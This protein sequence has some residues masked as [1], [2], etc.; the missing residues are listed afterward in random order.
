MGKK[1]GWH[2]W[3]GVLAS[4]AALSVTV[5]NAQAEK[6]D[7][8]HLQLI[9]G[10]K[11]VEDLV[12]INPDWVIGSGFDISNAPGHLYLVDTHSNK[13]EDLLPNISVKVDARAYPACPG[14]PDFD[15]LTPHGLDYY[16]QQH[17]LFVVNHGGR[18]SIEV[19]QLSPEAVGE[20]PKLTWVG[21]TLA[22]PHTYLDAVVGVKNNEM[23]VS[24]LWNPDDPAKNR[25]LAAGQPEGALYHW[26]EGGGFRAIEAAKAFSGPNGVLATRDGQTLFVNL[27]ASKRIARLDR[28]GKGYRV[29]TRPLPFF[30]DNIRWAP[31]QRSIYIGGQEPPM[32]KVT[33]C[34]AGP[35]AVCPEVRFQIDRLDPQTLGTQTLVPPGDYAGMGAGTGAIRVGNALWLS[36]FKGDAIGVV[37]V[38]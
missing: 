26:S 18:E 30:P 2:F 4:V 12:A 32:A 5:G 37:P 13:V 31:D 22:P 21:C 25:R 7:L 20:K 36:S 23:I 10:V 6:A 27:W 35:Q 1:R 15:K 19:F 11:N 29:R 14:A 17:R 9:K 3:G 33:A 8:R 16:P 38:K 28:A 24:S 34:L